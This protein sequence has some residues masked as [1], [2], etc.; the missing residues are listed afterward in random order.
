MGYANHI[1]RVGALAVTLGVG[2]AVASAPGVAY[3]DTSG[4]SDASQSSTSEKA[5]TSGDGSNSVTT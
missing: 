4:S 5:R 3:A 1:G 2:W